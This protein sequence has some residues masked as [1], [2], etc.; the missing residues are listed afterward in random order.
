MTD[1]Q[2]P[3]Q[4]RKPKKPFHHPDAYLNALSAAH[5]PLCVR[6]ADGTAI[7]DCRITR[8]DTYS[9]VVKSPESEIWIAKNSLSTIRLWTA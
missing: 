1:T 4:Q 8:V 5:M 6:L 3:V 2:Q 9:I 7:A